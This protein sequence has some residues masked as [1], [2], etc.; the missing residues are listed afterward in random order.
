MKKKYM[1]RDVFEVG[2]ATT[3]KLH[4]STNIPLEDLANRIWSGY[5]GSIIDD[6]VVSDWV[7]AASEGIA[8]MRKNNAEALREFFH[9]LQWYCMCHDDKGR[10]KRRRLFDGLRFQK[11]IQDPER[12]ENFVMKLTVYY[13]GLVS[14]LFPPAPDGWSLSNR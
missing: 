2:A 3:A 6:D 10:P 5:S 13:A 14:G 11:S 4:L 9:H 8:S 7:E 1:P 12:V